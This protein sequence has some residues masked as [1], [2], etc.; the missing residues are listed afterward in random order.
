MSDYDDNKDLEI[1]WGIFL[2][3]IFLIMV[4]LFTIIGVAVGGGIS[5][6]NYGIAVRNNFKFE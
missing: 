1:L 4:A 2:I 5:L 6:Y 3:V